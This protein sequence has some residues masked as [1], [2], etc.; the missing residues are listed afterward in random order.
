MDSQIQEMTLVGYYHFSS[1]DKQNHYFVV[2]CLFS[3]NDLSKNIMRGTMLN[4]YVD[5]LTYSKI[6]EDFNI[7]NSIKVEVRPNIN[8]GK[9]SYKIVL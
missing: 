9:V 4:I 2:Q 7:G 6:T 5:D 8:T 3:E 1:K